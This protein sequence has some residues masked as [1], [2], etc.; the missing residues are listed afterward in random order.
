M[1]G[2]LIAGVKH[3]RK[4]LATEDSRCEYL[5]ATEVREGVGDASRGGERPIARLVHELRQELE[6]V[7][8]RDDVGSTNCTGGLAAHLSRLHEC[9]FLMAH[10]GAFQGDGVELAARAGA[11]VALSTRFTNETVLGMSC[12]NRGDWAGSQVM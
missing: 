8:Y 2:R 4:R 10:G 11:L 9:E 6:S 12:R 7:R 3:H 5:Q 1:H